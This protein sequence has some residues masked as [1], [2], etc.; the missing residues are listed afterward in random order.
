MPTKPKIE[1]RLRRTMDMPNGCRFW[2]GTILS[3]GYGQLQVDGQRFLA[4]R[5]AYE[6][7]VGPI[8]EGLQIHHICNQRAC[9]KI[10][11]LEPVTAKE[12]QR[13][14]KRTP[15]CPKGHNNWVRWKSQE[16]R[17]CRTC[18]KSNAKKWRARK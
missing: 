2:V 11:H 9:V 8:P 4:H 6:Q 17:K 10:E 14:I 7:L 3:N 16:G 5:Y 15:L 13:R 18:N 12:N 1:Y